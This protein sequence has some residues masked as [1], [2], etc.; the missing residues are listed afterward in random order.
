VALQLQ[1]VLD[2]TPRFWRALGNKCVGLLKAYAAKGLDFEGRAFPGYSAKYAETKAA[3]RPKK[4]GGSAKQAGAGK[5]QA[6]RQ[7]NPPDLK[8][9]GDMLRDLKVQEAD[10]QGVVFGWSVLGDRLQWNADRG[11]SLIDMDSTTEVHP[12][13]TEALHDALALDTEEKLEKWAKEPIVINIK[14]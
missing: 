12:Q 6:S 7:T 3:G 14:R 13:V 11:R 10:T 9:S 5:R 4:S 8:F 1:D 2:R